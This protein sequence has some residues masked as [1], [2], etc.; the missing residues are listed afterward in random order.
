VDSSYVLHNCCTLC[1]TDTLSTALKTEE[2]NT[3]SLLL[4]LSV[5]SDQQSSTPVRLD[6][7]LLLLVV[8]VLVMLKV[9]LHDAMLE[10]SRYS[11]AARDYCQ[12]CWIKLS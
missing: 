3:C 6:R 7:L 5:N 8:V 4:L 1:L 10:F 9:Q 12:C 11:G 2:S